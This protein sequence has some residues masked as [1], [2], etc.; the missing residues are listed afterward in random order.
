MAVEGHGFQPFFRLLQYQGSV[1]FVQLFVFFCVG[2]EE[3]VGDY[4]LAA[5]EQDAVCRSAVASG[6]ACL[7]VVAFQ[8]LRHVVMDNEGDVGLVNS[9]TE[10]VGG[11]YDGRAVVEKAFLA[12]LPFLIG[13]PGVVTH[14]GISPLNQGAAHLFH[15]LA[16]RAVDDA[17]F[18]RML[19]QYAKRF[20]KFVLGMPDL[21]I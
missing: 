20:S 2:G 19:L 16:G 7:L 1:F 8:I 6:P 10:G 9:H 21:K 18:S 15:R 13:K 14:G 4:V 5:V 3:A 11:D 17:A 12:A